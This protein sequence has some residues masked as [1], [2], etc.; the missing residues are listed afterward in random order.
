MRGCVII[1]ADVSSF[2]TLDGDGLRSSRCHVLEYAPKKQRHVT[3]S[4]FAAELFGCCD[5]LDTMLVVI[6]ALQKVETGT[7]TA[8]Q[9]RR[10]R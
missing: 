6:L 8:E 2:G 4:T 9:A 7:V 3:R 1:R 5:T 10:L